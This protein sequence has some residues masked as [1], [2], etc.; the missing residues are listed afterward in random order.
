MEKEISNATM[1]AVVLI[2]LSVILGVCVSIFAIDKEIINE[3]VTQVADSL[4]TVEN[5]AFLDYDNTIV[6][7]TQVLSVLETAERQEV[8]LLVQTKQL[9]KAPSI[10]STV[11]VVTVMAREKERNYVNYGVC[12]S[13]TNELELINGRYTGLGVFAT[14]DNGL[15]V[16]NSVLGD[17]R[18]KGNIEYVN[19]NNK[20]HANLIQD[21]N[22]VTIGLAFSEVD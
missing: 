9:A 22:N 5:F 10:G 3:G 8:A 17:T 4:N 12:L 18:V 14:D 19:P 7:G 21:Y 13:D 20:F 16:R 1:L 6:T 15:V 11:P 2:A